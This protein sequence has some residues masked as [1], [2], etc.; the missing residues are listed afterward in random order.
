MGFTYILIVD[1]IVILLPRKEILISRWL[2][3]ARRVH[4]S[5]VLVVAAWEA[6]QLRVHSVSIG[7]EVY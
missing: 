3:S 7:M 5:K 6:K 1:D 4:P 2:L